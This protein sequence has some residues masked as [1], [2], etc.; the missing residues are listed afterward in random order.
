MPLKDPEARRAYNQAYHAEHPVD[1]RE[2]QREQYE[3]NRERV[4]AHQRERK[5]ERAAYYRQYRE[6]RKEEIAAKQKAYREANREE[7]ARK[8]R[9]YTEA[10]KERLKERRRDKPPNISPEA[11]ARKEERRLIQRTGFTSALIQTALEH[12]DYKCAICPTDLRTLRRR[13]WHADHCHDSRKP[14]GILCGPCNMALGLFRDDPE[15]LRAAIA[16][17]QNPPLALV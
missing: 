7:L 15:R 10:N 3:K 1:R 12:Q 9:E 2:Y 17:L 13:D 8:K 4:L 16:Y 6:A 11:L 5:A 14:R